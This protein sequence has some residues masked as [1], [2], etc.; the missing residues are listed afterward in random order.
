MKVKCVGKKRGAF[1]TDKG[2]Y[3]EYAKLMCIFPMTQVN[4]GVN[5][6]VGD[7]VQAIAIPFDIFDSIPD[8]ACEL[9]LEFNQK[10]R[11]I[12]VDIA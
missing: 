9:D 2:E 1:T 7:E 3:L 4:D 6:S 5:V 12:G 10:G 11:V 8:E